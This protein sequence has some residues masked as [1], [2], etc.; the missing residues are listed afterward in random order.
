MMA[1]DFKNMPMSKKMGLQFT[2]SL[3]VAGVVFY[4]AKRNV[5]SKRK[6]E[7][8]EYRADF[9]Y[10]GLPFGEL[11]AGRIEFLQGP[12]NPPIVVFRK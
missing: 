10:V 1:M 12:T 9:D 2:A 7:L 8:D 3:A 4:L 11:G 6:A 5:A